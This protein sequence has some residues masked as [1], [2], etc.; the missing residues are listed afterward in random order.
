MSGWGVST[1]GK[2]FLT[3]AAIRGAQKLAG[4]TGPWMAESDRGGIFTWKNGALIG[5]IWAGM[6]SGSI[7]VGVLS[8]LGSWVTVLVLALI[9][10]L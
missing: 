9:T 4:D 2:L 8:A 3:G 1:T 6:K 10:W 7:I 5:G